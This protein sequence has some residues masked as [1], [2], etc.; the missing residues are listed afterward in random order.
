MAKGKGAKGDGSGGIRLTGHPRA[1]RHISHAKGWGGLAAFVLVLVLSLQ[2]GVPVADAVGRGVAG[3]VA[4]YLLGWGIAVTVWRQIALAELEHLR[5][6]LVKSMHD[7]AVAGDATNAA[8]R[9]A[10]TEARPQST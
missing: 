8:V 4:G 1:Q 3:G 10:K 5:R 7:Q 2:A 6:Q 9:G